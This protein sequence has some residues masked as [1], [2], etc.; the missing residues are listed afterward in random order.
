M[1]QRVCRL[2]D[3]SGFSSSSPRRSQL[4]SRALRTKRDK[5]LAADTPFEQ[6]KF[7]DCLDRGCLSL[8]SVPSCS[9]IHT[10]YWLVNYSTELGYRNMHR[11]KTRFAPQKHPMLVSLPRHAIANGL[12]GRWRRLISNL[13][14][15][16]LSKAALSVHLNPVAIFTGPLYSSEKA[17]P[18]HRPCSMLM[19]I[20]SPFELPAQKKKKKKK[21]SLVRRDGCQ[22]LSWSFARSLYLVVGSVRSSFGAGS[23]GQFA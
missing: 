11:L 12:V 6:K 3:L 1:L 5:T 16:S 2:G 15:S 18:N 23:P 22:S 13:E 4:L 20:M 9:S 14:V 21:K 10:V 7:G 19:P 8:T 17:K